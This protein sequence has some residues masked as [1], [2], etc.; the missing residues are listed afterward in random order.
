MRSERLV[1]DRPQAGE[2]LGRGRLEVAQLVHLP[3]ELVLALSEPVVREQLVVDDV[4]VGADE[5][6]RR[7]DMFFVVIDAR[8]ERRAD[9]ELRVRKRFVRSS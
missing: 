5:R 1:D 9:D 7:P 4:L 3:Q 2:R 6:Q 8:N